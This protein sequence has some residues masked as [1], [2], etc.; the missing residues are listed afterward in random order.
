[1]TP[2]TG[3]ARISV[4]MPKMNTHASI[5]KVSATRL[6]VESVGNLFP[7]ARSVKGQLRDS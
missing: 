4:T 6:R 1:M 2:G 5:V 7:C 3:S